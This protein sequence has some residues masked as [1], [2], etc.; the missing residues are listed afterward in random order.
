MARVRVLVTGQHH[1]SLPE[2]AHDLNVESSAASPGNR[3]HH[4]WAIDQVPV[5][6]APGNLEHTVGIFPRLGGIRFS[7]VT[8]SPIA[9]ASVPTGLPTDTPEELRQLVQKD[10]GGFHATPTLDFGYV[11]SGEIMLVL[12]DGHYRA[13]R[14]GDAFVQH[15]VTHSWQN[16]SDK[17]CVVVFVLIGTERAAEQ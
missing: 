7:L 17:P 6:P 12:P 13:L 10:T 11:V 2:F 5:V 1:A 3:V 15:G 4:L 16:R 14:A 8:F 9:Q